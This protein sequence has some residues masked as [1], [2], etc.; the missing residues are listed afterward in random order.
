M[1]AQAAAVPYH[2]GQRGHGHFAHHLDLANHLD[3]APPRAVQP[4]HELEKRRR[5]RRLQPALA[6][7]LLRIGA[8]AHGHGQRAVLAQ[9]LQGGKVEGFSHRAPARSISAGHGQKTRRIGGALGQL[10]GQHRQVGGS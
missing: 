7:E 3:Y 2:G 5:A 6:G 8:T 10:G 9:Q 1:L 4:R